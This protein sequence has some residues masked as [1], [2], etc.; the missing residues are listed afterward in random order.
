[1]PDAFYLLGK[2]Y[3]SDKKDAT[4]A[5]EN[6]RLAGTQAFGDALLASQIYDELAQIFE[7]KGDKGAAR[8]NY[9]K[10]VLSEDNAAAFCR[11][12]RFLVKGGAAQ[13]KDQIKAL[14][15]K[16]VENAPRGECAGEMKGYAQ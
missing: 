6:F 16:Y 7:E 13:D 9:E 15:K 10:A 11:F 8:D 2:I 5:I 3:R 4:K 12:V 1:M 14:A